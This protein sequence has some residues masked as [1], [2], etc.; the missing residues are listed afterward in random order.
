MRTNTREATLLE[1]MQTVSV[2][3]KSIYAATLGEGS[4]PDR[5]E[6]LREAEYSKIMLNRII[7]K[8]SRTEGEK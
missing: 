4:V 6:V 8:L 7:Y 2:L 1:K 5:K 3:L